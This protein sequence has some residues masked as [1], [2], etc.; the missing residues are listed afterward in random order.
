M[1]NADYLMRFHIIRTFHAKN[2]V[3]KFQFFSCE[4]WMLEILSM[5]TF[6]RSYRVNDTLFEVK[7]GN[8]VKR[9]K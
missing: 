2:E 4:S 5:I 1:D 6:M 3:K 9:I 8:D 7:V